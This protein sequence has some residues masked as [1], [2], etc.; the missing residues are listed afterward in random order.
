MEYPK[1]NIPYLSL[2]SLLGITMFN[3]LICFAGH[4]TT[5]INLSLISITFPV[6]I[7]ILSR[8]FFR[9][10]ITINK[11]IG[12]MLVATGVILLI[13]KGI[14]SKILDISFAI[15][16]LWMLLAAITFAVYN[17]LLKRKHLGFPVQHV[18]SGACFSVS[19]LSLGICNSSAC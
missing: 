9:E 12:I 1:K 3:T 5:A 17:I 6:F 7:V 2:T 18:H 16:D 15:G 13:T 14:L 10:R 19:V 4:T 11:G 8:I